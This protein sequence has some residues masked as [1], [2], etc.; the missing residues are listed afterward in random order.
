MQTYTLIIF[1]IDC[2]PI[3]VSP[4]QDQSLHMR[5][6][7]SFSFKTT[8][9]MLQN[10]EHNSDFFPLKPTFQAETRALQAAITIAFIATKCFFTPIFVTNSCLKQS[11]F[12]QVSF[13][14]F[15]YDDIVKPLIQGHIKQG[16]CS[17]EP[18]LLVEDVSHVIPFNWI[19]QESL[20]CVMSPHINT[21]LQRKICLNYLQM[22]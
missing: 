6:G 4:N 22:Q 5:S 19:F 1:S 14:S 15:V 21:Q 2:V 16:T 3:L 11:C 20:V 7:S 12:L 18:K 17:A 13:I 9:A 8:S 10:D